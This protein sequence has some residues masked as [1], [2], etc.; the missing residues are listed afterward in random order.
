VVFPYLIAGRRVTRLNTELQRALYVYTSLFQNMRIIMVQELLRYGGLTLVAGWLSC[1]FSSELMSIAGRDVVL[2]KEREDLILLEL[3]RLSL[4]P[5]A[6]APLERE[7]AVASFYAF[8]NL[9]LDDLKAVVEK[10]G[11]F[12]T[13]VACQR[14]DLDLLR[15][16]AQEVYYIKPRD[17]IIS[18]LNEALIDALSLARPRDEEKALKKAKREELGLFEIYILRGA[19]PA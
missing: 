10:Y 6:P 2:V 5:L 9:P 13:A 11:K 3:D 4:I 16:V 19:G 8:E 7:L 15:E 12:D 1:G 14:G 17:P 18:F